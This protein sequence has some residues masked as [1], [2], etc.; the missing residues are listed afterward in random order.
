MVCL[1][2]IANSVQSSFVPA[3]EGTIWN[4]HLKFPSFNKHKSRAIVEK[5][6]KN[7][8]VTIYRPKIK[9]SM[10][11]QRKRE[12]K[13]DPFPF[14]QVSIPPHS[15]FNNVRKLKALL[16]EIAL[17]LRRFRTQPAWNISNGSHSSTLI[18]LRQHNYSDLYHEHTACI[19]F[20]HYKR[21]ERPALAIA[22]I[23]Q[24]RDVGANPRRFQSDFSALRLVGGKRR[25]MRSISKTRARQR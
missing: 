9:A 4:L 25:G 24:Y 13:N 11:L 22:I 5:K 18:Y 12:N 17:R 1:V 7:K 15:L 19:C 20:F 6:T 14:R 8:N 3:Y 2:P 16:Q 10:E 21:T 23:F